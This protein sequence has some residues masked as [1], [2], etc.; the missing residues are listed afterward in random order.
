[1]YKKL[2][3][4]VLSVIALQSVKA[5]TEKGSQ[6]LGL[7]FGVSTQNS[8]TSYYSSYTNSYGTN[9]K[10]KQT[11]Y[12]IAPSYSYFIADK[13]DIGASLSYGQSNTK[14]DPAINTSTKQTSRGF[15]ASIFLR[16]YFL[17][18]NKI[19]IRTGP[20]LSYEKAKQTST[21]TDSQNNINS[22]I[23]NYGGGLNLD[24]VY[25]PTKNIGL[26]AG[27]ANLSYRH[28]KNKGYMEG[29][30]NTFNLSMVNN[31]TLSIY[32]VFGK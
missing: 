11:S 24:F 1:M 25:Y 26:A 9:S 32:Y 8:N 22:D 30:S 20:Y 5:Q 4:V 12:N 29:S 2:L 17:Y 13:L 18:D 3:L 27:L 14:Y 31:L 10:G 21:Y 19:G 28:Q 15:D 16:K 23:D 7:S 6:N